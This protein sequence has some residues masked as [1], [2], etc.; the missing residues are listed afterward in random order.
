VTAD[1]GRAASD[2]AAFLDLGRGK[3]LVLLR[4]NDS[5]AAMWA[6]VA[7]L[8]AE[9]MRLI[10][11]NEPVASVSEV[12]SMVQQAGV[13]RFAVLAHGAA[14]PVAVD[15]AAGDDVDALVLIGAVG[16][17]ST[18]AVRRIAER[19]IPVFLLWGED[20][21]V[22]SAEDAERL[23]ERLPASTLALVPGAGHDVLQ[24]A[25][26]TVVPLVFEYLRARYLGERHGHAE[27]GGPVPIALTR[28][29]DLN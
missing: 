21:D 28:R 1:G 19:E 17:G 3:P 11:P 10:V 25:A 27:V 9:A 16:S 13:E 12:E 22:S 7:P 4:G 20:D 15:V 26:A 8:L 29:P 2:D 24:Q 6:S 14:G 23:S 5:S 18:Q